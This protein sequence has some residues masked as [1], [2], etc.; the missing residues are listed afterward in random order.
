MWQGL[1]L[2]MQAM[3][4]QTRPHSGAGELLFSLMADVIHGEFMVTVWA[5][6]LLSETRGF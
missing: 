1:G 4:G 2:R 6:E 5:Q 3:V